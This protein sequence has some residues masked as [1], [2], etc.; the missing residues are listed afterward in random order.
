MQCDQ[1]F[2]LDRIRHR[3]TDFEFTFRSD[4]IIEGTEFLI[5][6]LQLTDQTQQ[7]N[8]NNAGNIFFQDTSTITILDTT[9]NYK[10]YL[11]KYY[12]VHN[13]TMVSVVY[14]G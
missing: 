5:L 6:Q 12:Y 3:T 11:L 14:V 7:S 2:T 4:N 9:G 13:C 1:S 10:H 8:I